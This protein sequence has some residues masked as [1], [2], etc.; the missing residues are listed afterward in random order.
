MATDWD[1]A[2][3]IFTALT[4][5]ATVIVALGIF[6]LWQQWRAS[7]QTL[8]LQAL[9]HIYEQFHTREGK[10]DRYA[11]Y[12]SSLKDYGQQ[13]FEELWNSRD[14]SRSLL[15]Q[16]ER[17]ADLVHYIGLLASRG[18]ISTEDL[19][20][21]FMWPA[22][23]SYRHLARYIQW[24][25]D[26]HNPRYGEQFRYLV[27]RLEALF[28]NEYGANTFSERFGVD[29]LTELTPAFWPPI[30]PRNPSIIYPPPS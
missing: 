20:E 5:V 27:P 9:I 6:F 7:S 4:A 18:L 29:S 25:R 26:N 11:I 1:K 24:I 28:K 14:A 19:A 22:L 2:T 12:T 17:T 16:V 23:M 15:P 10:D 8:R 21:Y 13:Q 3:S 30:R